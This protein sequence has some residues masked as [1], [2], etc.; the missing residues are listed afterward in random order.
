MPRTTRSDLQALA[1]DVLRAAGLAAPDAEAAAEGLALASARGVDSHGVAR[2]PQYVASIRGGMVNPAPEPRIR[3]QRGATVLVDA[4]GGY[5][6]RPAALAMDTAVEL[7]G[8]YGVAVAA[9]RNSHHFGAAGIHALRAA[10]QRM[11]GMVT[12][13]AKARIAPWGATRAVLGNNPLAVAVPRRPPDPAMVLD[14]ALGQVAIGRLRLAAAAGE[15]VPEG[16]GFDAQGRPTTDPRAI[17]DGGLIAPVGGHKGSG[18]ALML[19]VLAGVLPAAPFAVA[20]DPHGRDG[21]GHLLVAVDPACFRELEEFYDDLERLVAQV[22]QAPVRDGGEPVRLP[23]QR[24]HA[25]VLAA[26]PE[27]LV[28]TDRLAADLRALLAELDLEPPSWIGG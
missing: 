6:Y 5:G 25:A 17:I 8:G 11:I 26:E 13:T 28:L 7:A 22:R 9:V 18:L 21:V 23:G 10:T 2:L 14:V 4:D 15:P 19:E 20:A 1:R 3:R 16:W 24:A 27:G 12:S